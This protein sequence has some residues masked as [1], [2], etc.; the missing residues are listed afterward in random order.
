MS[1]E[2]THPHTLPARDHPYQETSVLWPWTIL[3]RTRQ[4]RITNRPKLPPSNCQI[5]INQSTKALCSQLTLSEPRCATSTLSQRSFLPTKRSG[6]PTVPL[7]TT[8]IH[9]RSSKGKL[10]QLMISIETSQRRNKMRSFT[11]SQWSRSR[12]CKGSSGETSYAILNLTIL[13]TLK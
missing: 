5:S 10:D 2:S 3:M 9:R 11:M 13:N 12:P 1:L 6:R 7:H 8:I 4:N